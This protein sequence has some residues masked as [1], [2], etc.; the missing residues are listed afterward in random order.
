LVDFETIVDN[1]VTS[2]YAVDYGANNIVQFN[3]NWEYLSNKTLV[4]GSYI[5]L[6]DNEFFISSDSGILKTASYF[7]S[8]VDHVMDTNAQL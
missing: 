2:Y 3:E 6:V 7:S 1:N 5:K 4:K 8:I